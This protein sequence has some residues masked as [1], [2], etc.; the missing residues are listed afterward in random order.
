[1]PYIESASPLNEGH[2]SPEARHFKRGYHR[3][4]YGC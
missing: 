3:E 2:L 4:K 1:M